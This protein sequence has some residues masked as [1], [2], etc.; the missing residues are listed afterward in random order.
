VI[1][2]EGEIVEAQE[3]ETAGAAGKSDSATR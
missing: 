2:I 1:N 3:A